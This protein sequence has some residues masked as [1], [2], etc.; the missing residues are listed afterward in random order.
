MTNTIA[1]LGPKGGPG[2]TTVARNL[3]YELA[4][5]GHKTLQADFDPQAN[6]TAANGLKL[7]ASS[8]TIYRAM[9]APDKDGA[10]SPLS[11]VTK[12]GDNLYILPADA[13]L[14]GAQAEFQNDVDRNY[15][16]ADVL[17]AL[18]SFDYVIID[19]P[20]GLNF[21]TNNALWAATHALAVIEPETDAYES[22]PRLQRSVLLAQRLRNDQPAWLGIVV[23]KRDKRITLHQVAIEQAREE[24]KDQVFETV[25]PA[26]A[27]FKYARAYRLSVSEHEPGSPGSEAFQ[28]LAAEVIERVQARST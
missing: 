24:Y 22:I 19:C 8:P 2:K 5:L 7:T 9:L 15:K 27:A 17:A 23:N 25:I 10:I 3:A 12:A 20:P 21:F 1:V 18:P 26:S 6:L 14:D 13:N 4:R 16:L 28:A 11:A